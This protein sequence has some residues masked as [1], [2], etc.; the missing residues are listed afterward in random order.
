MGD[1]GV[2]EGKMLLGEGGLA[3]TESEGEGLEGLPGL[4]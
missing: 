4:R 1:D 3:E 2:M